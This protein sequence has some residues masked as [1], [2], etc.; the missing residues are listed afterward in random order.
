MTKTILL[1]TAAMA[2]SSCSATDDSQAVPDPAQG[3]RHLSQA[4]NYVEISDH[5]TTSGRI[6]NHN[7]EQIKDAGYE[8]IIN[9]DTADRERNAEEAFLA[10]DQGLTYFQIPVN[11]RQPKQR[12]LDLFFDLM[13]SVEGRKVYVHCSGNRRASVFV[14]LYRLLRLRENPDTAWRDVLRVWDPSRQSHWSDFIRSA[15]QRHGG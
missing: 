1:V 8:V 12:D 15:Q 3:V 14:Y 9:L 2:F 13:D 10:V 4:R 11:G 7:L 6:E 5:L